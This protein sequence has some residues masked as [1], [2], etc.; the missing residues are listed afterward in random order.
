MNKIKAFFAKVAAFF[1]GGNAQKALNTA[2]DFVPKALPIIDIAADI[3]VGLTPTT[4]DDAVL[5]MI[6]A[7]YPQLFNGSLQNGDQVKLFTL[8]VATDLLKGAFPSLST[9]I[10][11]LA[12]QTAYTGKNA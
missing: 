9:S 11:R 8:G 1:A 7:K 2:A 3:A 6:K 12:V 4:V 5:A 10:A